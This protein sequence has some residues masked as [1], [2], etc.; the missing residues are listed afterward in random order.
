MLADPPERVERQRR[1]HQWYVGRI[2]RLMEVRL[3]VEEQVLV[4][5]RPPE[6]VS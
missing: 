1:F 3:Q 2:G 5:Q 6:P 4:H